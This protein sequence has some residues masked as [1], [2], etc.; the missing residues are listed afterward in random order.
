MGSHR[1]V[2][3]VAHRVSQGANGIVEDEQILVL[4]FAEGK[5]E[6]VQDVAEVR[7]QLRA[8]LLL[9]G[10]EGT[11]RGRSVQWAA[12]GGTGLW[13]GFRK[14]TLGISQYEY[15]EKSEHC[16]ES[17]IITSQRAASGAGE[18]RSVGPG[19]K[20]HLQAASCTLLLPSRIRLSSSV[21]RGFR[22]MSGGW[23]TTQWA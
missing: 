1:L 21:I 4:V 12:T 6:G 11:G 10:G 16:Q 19:V 18:V 5:D 13:V 17:S 9:Q 15:S 20:G 3:V 2:E 23:L 8:G 14:G 7:H 22:C